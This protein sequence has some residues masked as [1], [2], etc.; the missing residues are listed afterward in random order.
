MRKPRIR[1]PRRQKAPR[2]THL[3]ARITEEDGGFTLH[4]RLYDEAQ[5][6]MA[7]WGEEIADSIETVSGLLDALAQ[8]HSIPQERIRIRMQMDN[9]RE[10]T[11]H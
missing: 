9:A 1:T 5:P 8:E 3:S 11:L 4:V 7:A 2:Y 10:G 6:A